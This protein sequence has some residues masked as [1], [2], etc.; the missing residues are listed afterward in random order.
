MLD[1]LPPAACFEGLAGTSGE[2]YEKASEIAFAAMS[3]HPIPLASPVMA[4]TLYDDGVALLTMLERAHKNCFTP[5]HGRDRG[6]V[7]APLRRT[8]L[9][10]RGAD[11]P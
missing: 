3:G 4:L 11:R 9:Q 5:V 6:G 2:A 10:G 1:D 8:G 7:C